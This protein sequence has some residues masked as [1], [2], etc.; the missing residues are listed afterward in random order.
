MTVRLGNMCAQADGPVPPGVI[1]V[2]NTCL[3]PG[4]LSL[5]RGWHSDTHASPAEGCFHAKTAVRV[6]PGTAQS[7][8]VHGLE[9][10]G[11]GGGGGWSCL[12]RGCLVQGRTSYIF[13][14]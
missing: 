7:K 1:A 6:S 10:G 11:G 9:R 5:L 8:P 13:N 3:V 2:T 4:S 12:V 14:L